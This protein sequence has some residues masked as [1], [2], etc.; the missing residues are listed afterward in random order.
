MSLAVQEKHTTLRR[1]KRP[2]DQHDRPVGENRLPYIN[3]WWRL[4]LTL[5]IG[6]GGT[7]HGIFKRHVTIFIA[8]HTTKRPSFTIS[9]TE[10]K[11]DKH[12]SAL[13]WKV[14]NY[15]RAVALCRMIFR[16]SFKWDLCSVQRQQ[17]PTFSLSGRLSMK[18][19]CA[20]G[21]SA[22]EQRCRPVYLLVWHY[23]ICPPPSRH[24]F[25][26]KYNLERS[27]SW[28]GSRHK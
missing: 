17:E 2:I 23:C 16:S 7:I 10:Q 12:P 28:P 6:K 22:A 19:R 24:V 26:E 20:C 1:R 13:K 21:Y 8:F 27:M 14:K 4:E 3:R 11:S 25:S 5:S 18:S 9:H 15:N